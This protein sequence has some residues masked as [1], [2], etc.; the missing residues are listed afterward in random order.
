M[1]FDSLGL[2]DIYGLHHVPFWQQSWF[3]YCCI[4]LAILL[5]A[6]LIA[7]FYFFFK[8]RMGK[9][10][11]KPWEKALH[12]LT[13]LKKRSTSLSNACMYDELTHIIKEYMQA[14]YFLDCQ[15]KTDQEVGK[16]LDQN[17]FFDPTGKLSQ[18]LHN[19]IETKFSPESSNRTQCNQDYETVVAFV[20]AT[21][22][23]EKK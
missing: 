3:W 10:S 21:I 18:V 4:G 19:S 12:A 6:A 17:T 11:Q 14:R 15:G 1:E 16:Q 9:K 2:Y 7:G 22:P 5:G 23:Q 20:S 13:L 8:S